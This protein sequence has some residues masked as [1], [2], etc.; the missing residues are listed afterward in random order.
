MA[1][2]LA[3]GCRESSLSGAG[4]DR[5]AWRVGEVRSPL[6]SG[7]IAADA[8]NVYAYTNNYA[9]AAIRLSD[10]RRLWSA[11]GDETSN[12]EAGTQGAAVCSETVIFNSYLA[13]YGVNSA[14]GARRWR[15]RPSQGGGTGYGSPICDSGTVYIGTARPMRVYAVDVATGA[16]RWA[17]NVDRN[18]GGNGFVATPRV[19]EGV[20]VACTREFGTPLTGMIAA[21]DAGSGRELWRYE[22]TPLPPFEHSS[23][24]RFVAVARS[25]A[26]G[27]LDD[28]R[29]VALELRTGV[30]RWTAAPVV[31]LQSSI[32]E[33]PLAIVDDTILAIGSLSGVVTA[34]HVDTGRELWRSPALTESVINNGLLADRGQVMAVSLSGWAMAFDARTGRRQWTVRAGP[35]LNERTMFPPGVLT[36]SLFI[37]IATDGLYAFRR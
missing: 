4:G 2:A 37:A 25:L 18:S 8:N 17:A 20:V 23:C 12:I 34:V 35:A 16:E 32:D 11:A 7:A 27:A 14:T 26:I 29:V 15:W 13:T 9:I 24:G 3:G 1:A 6:R 31:G 22:W 10:Q 30:V 21:I 5:I 28:G 36:P 19:G 33:R